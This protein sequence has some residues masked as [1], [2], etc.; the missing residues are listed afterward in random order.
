MYRHTWAELPDWEAFQEAHGD[1]VQ[2]CHPLRAG[3]LC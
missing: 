1:A 3:V 2:A